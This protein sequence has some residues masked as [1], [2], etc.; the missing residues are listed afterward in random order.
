MK[1]F[2]AK[3]IL[4]LGAMLSFAATPAMAQATRTWVSGVGDDANPCSRTAPCKTF[5]GAIS[6]TAAG[7]EINTL[8]PG[9]F[10]AVTITKSI[11][12]R[13]DST[14]AGILAAGTNGI[15]I[16]AAAS[17]RVVI[18]GIDFEGVG[19]GLN[20]VS[21]LSAGQVEVR[22]STIRNF[23]VS[24]VSITGNQ[25]VR[26]TVDNVHFSNMPI[27]VLV[28]VTTGKGQ[29]RINDSIFVNQTTAGL[30]VNGTANSAFVNASSFW[31]SPKGLQ[32]LS[33]GTVTSFGNNAFGTPANDPPTTVTPLG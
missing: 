6:K 5:A 31:G 7:G 16:N 12:I 8:D 17:D 25:Q 27:G 29:A 18:D 32:I 10:G 33:G 9:A 1:F 11:T 24:G 20:A 28:G 15:V 26:V 19:T 4:I 22:N 30:S 14:Q 3:I 21:V 23:S 2:W 13:S